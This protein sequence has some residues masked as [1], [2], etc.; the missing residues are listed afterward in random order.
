MRSDEGS[1][2]SVHDRR[3]HVRMESRVGP[4]VG[5]HGLGAVEDDRIAASQPS[6]VNPEDDVRV[7][8]ADECFEVAIARGRE[9]R[10]PSTESAS[11]TEPSIRYATERK[12]DRC[13]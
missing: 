3:Q 10:G 9:E 11:A 7:E 6:A 2:G 1:C 13:C 4:R 12:C 5:G 8:N